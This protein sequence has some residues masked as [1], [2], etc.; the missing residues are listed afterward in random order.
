MANLIASGA[1]DSYATDHGAAGAPDGQKP[2]DSAGS[3]RAWCS[4]L[5]AHGAWLMAEQCDV[6]PSLGRSGEE[7]VGEG[8]SISEAGLHESVTVNR[9]MTGAESDY[10]T[11]RN[12]I[13]HGIDAHYSGRL[14]FFILVFVYD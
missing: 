14:L 11:C 13:S 9:L 6:F 10:L 4:W 1:N 7:K 3:G 12:K 8:S 2:E 5:I